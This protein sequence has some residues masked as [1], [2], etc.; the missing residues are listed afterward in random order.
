MAT[1]TSGGSSRLNA[2]VLASPAAG[3]AYKLALSY[4]NAAFSACANGGTVSTAAS[5]TVPGGL[6]MLR[7]GSDG[8]A[9]ANGWVR[10]VT[11]FPHKLPDAELKLLTA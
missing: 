3:T 4:R 6:N 7:L 10:K 11:Y 2:N 9:F 1:I 8:G 5:G